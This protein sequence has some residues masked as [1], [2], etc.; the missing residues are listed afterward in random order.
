MATVCGDYPPALIPQLLPV[1]VDQYFS[2]H[3]LGISP[4]T[5]RPGPGSVPQ[6]RLDLADAAE[7][8]EILTFLRQ[9]LAAD[10]RLQALL[11][12]RMRRRVGDATRADARRSRSRTG[13]AVP[14]EHNRCQSC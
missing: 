2:E 10:P 14:V 8:A 7:L 4:G 3:G 12:E 13:G 1:L 9:W 6:L 5:G 11:A